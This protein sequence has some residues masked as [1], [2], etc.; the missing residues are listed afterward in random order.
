MAVLTASPKPLRSGE[1]AELSGL[2][3]ANRLLEKDLDANDVY[4]K[5]VGEYFAKSPNKDEAAAFVKSLAA[6]GSA[7]NK[8]KWQQQLASWRKQAEPNQPPA[9]A[10]VVEPNKTATAAAPAAPAAKI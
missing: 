7:E 3:K 4:V 8:P 10:P 5:K 2:D 9:I 1:I 6:V